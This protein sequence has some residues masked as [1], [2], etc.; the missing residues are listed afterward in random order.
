MEQEKKDFF[1]SYT[2]ADQ[3]WAEWIAW[4]LEDAGYTTVLQAWDFHPGSNFVQ[5]MQKALVNSHRAIAVLSTR[6][7]QSAYCMAEWSSAFTEDPTGEKGILIPVRIET[8]DPEGLHKAIVYIDL[9]RKEKQEAKTFLLQ[10]LQ[11]VI[12]KSRRKPKDE[13]SYPGQYKPEPRFPGSLPNVWNIPR[14]NPNFTGRDQL[15]KELHA[16]LTGGNHTAL[17]QHSLHGLGGIG[18]TQLAIEYAYRYTTSYEYAWWIR[19]EEDSGIIADYTALATALQLPEKDAEEQEAIIRAVRQWLNTRHGWLL[20]F[21]NARDADTLRDY[22]PDGAGGHVLI[23]SRNPDWKTI[24]TPLE[25]KVWQ[26]D[27]S[28]AFLKER[29]GLDQQTD[30]NLLAEELGDL[31]LALE[32]AAAYIDKSRIT[33]AEYLELFRTHRKDL[34]DRATPPAGY[35][36]TV[37]TT[38][39]M[40]FEAIRDVPLASDILFYSSVIAPDLIPKDLVKHALQERQNDQENENRQID[41]LV[42]NAA[43][44]ALCSY[45]LITSDTGTFSIH[46]LVQATIQDRIGPEATV[47]YRTV[48]LK[49]LRGQF[50]GEGYR[51]PSCWPECETLLPHAE[52]LTEESDPSQTIATLLN[53]MGGYYYGRASYAKAESLDRRSLAILEELL[54]AEH[55]SVATSLND[56]A[57][58]LKAHG[59]YVEAEPLYRR[60]LAIGE[61]VLGSEDP[62]VATRLN[63]LAELLRAQGKYGEAE[64]LYRRAL[65]IDEKVLGSEDPNVAIR[66]NNLALLLRE[67]GKYAE[68]ELLQRRSLAICEKQLGAEHPY[69][70]TSL[71]NLAGLLQHQG[72]YVEAEPLY[73]CALAIREQ[74]L[75][76]EHS[77][78]A[79]S[80]NDLAGLLRAQG[81]YVEAEPLYRRAVRICEQSLGASHP[82]TIMVKKNL[83][84]LLEDMKGK[85]Q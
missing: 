19:S 52:K 8:C 31:P 42:F 71:N 61:K 65:A 75:G 15:L 6:Y 82:N 63:N 58:S 10:E 20:V 74:R 36:D 16:S 77:D 24:G 23:T 1:I 68:A 76:A 64:P 18:K 13:P 54:G 9:V 41:P 46:R 48:M 39:A 29:T 67:Q 11:H 30:A 49:V 59:K 70:A 66:L 83:T 81:K 27:E 47:R 38:W 32:Q 72:K 60:A 34:L 50:P 73:R 4:H 78:V 43:V 21:D 85:G 53:R 28:I 12:E 69:V 14:R 44:D 62:S 80:L 33:I 2:G 7:L 35:P 37:A 25:I 84:I 79:Q 57:L 51:N 26:R 17:T 45:S 22:L 55:P 40:A 3:Q 56:L 5:D